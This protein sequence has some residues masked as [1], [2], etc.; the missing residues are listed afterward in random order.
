[1]RQDIRKGEQRTF[2][3]ALIEKTT[4]PQVVSTVTQLLCQPANQITVVRSEA[5][6]LLA[7]LESQIDMLYSENRDWVYIGSR[8]AFIVGHHVLLEA[9]GCVSELDYIR[10]AM[11][12]L[13]M[14]SDM[15][16]KYLKAFRAYRNYE[17]LF[18]AYN[19]DLGWNAEAL[20]DKKLFS[21]LLILDKA[22]GVKCNPLNPS[23]SHDEVFRHFLDDSLRDFRNFIDPDSKANDELRMKMQDYRQVLKEQFQMYEQVHL[24]TI[25]SGLDIDRAWLIRQINEIR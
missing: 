7:Y 10:K 24:L 21:K 19:Y 16:K 23:A 9:A 11:S 8:L 12:R 20:E 15:A 14:S 13:G 3:L 22:F 6:K 17:H 2:P 18:V 25:P 1:M 5:E 4:S